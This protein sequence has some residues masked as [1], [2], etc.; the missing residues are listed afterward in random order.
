[1]VLPRPASAN[2]H[3]LTVHA[4]R[5]ARFIQVIPRFIGITPFL[6]G[7]R[8]PAAGDARGPLGD[9]YRSYGQMTTS[10][11]GRIWKDCDMSTVRNK[12]QPVERTNH[13]SDNHNHTMPTGKVRL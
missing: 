11:S 1:V 10:L 13:E 5:Q 12:D 3:C 4:P 7:D 2:L 8:L 9:Y 6:Y